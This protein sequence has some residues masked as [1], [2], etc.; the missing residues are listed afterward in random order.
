MARKAMPARG[1]LA[2][3]K[4]QAGVLQPVIDTNR[5]EGKG[6]CVAIC[7]VHVFDMGV[8]A[9]EHRGAL[10]VVGKI[11]GFVHGWKQALIVDAAAC[12]GCGLCVQAC[13]E[14]AITLER[15]GVA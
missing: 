11:K 6:P 7:P 5:C 13:P 8:L 15:V 9:R 14:H 2:A 10:T 12:H 1:S 3:C 4:H